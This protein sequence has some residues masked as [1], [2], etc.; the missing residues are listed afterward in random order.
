MTLSPDL[1]RLSPKVVLHDHLDG[2][3]R[4][5]TV[6]DLARAQGISAPGSTADEVAEWFFRTADSG[7]LTRYLETFD[8]TVGLMQTP[9]ALQRVAR[10]YVEDMASDHV[11]YAETRWAPQQHAA[12]GLTMAE[13]VDAVQAGLDEGMA[14]VAELGRPVVVNQLITMMRQ[15]DPDPALAVLVTERLGH[16]VVGVDLA[17]PE[18]GFGPGRFLDLFDDIAEAGG[19]VTI[20]AGEGDG[21]GSIRAALE[22]GAERLGHGVRLAEDITAYGSGILQLGEVAAE[23]LQAAIALEVCPSSNVQTGLC[24]SVGDHPVGLLWQAGLPMTISPDN[25]LMSRT[26]ASRELSLTGEALGW[27]LEDL[28]HVAVTAADAA[29]CDEATRE[30]IR[31]RLD[32]GFAGL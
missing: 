29:F 32:E 5:A 9:E 24:P 4:P 17:G 28:H 6:L 18:A 26:S 25:R 13:A 7:S 11:I 21:P 14:E 30:I 15:L 3:L 12:G 16:G 27:E 10:E 20:H 22:C 8:V 2:G 31:E 23:V 19:H 1:V